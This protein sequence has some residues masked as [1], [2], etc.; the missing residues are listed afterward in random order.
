MLATR[1]DHR[2][3]CILLCIT[4]SFCV[5]LRS[6]ILSWLSLFTDCMQAVAHDISVIYAQQI[7]HNLLHSALNCFLFIFFCYRHAVLGVVV[8]RVLC[9]FALFP[10]F[11]SRCIIAFRAW[12]CHRFAVIVTFTVQFTSVAIIGAL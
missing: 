12:N 6:L 10:F 11:S 1:Q 7:S 8:Q 4:I 2:W 5:D 3:F 9:K